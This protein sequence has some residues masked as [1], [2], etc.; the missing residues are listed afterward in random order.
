MMQKSALVLGASGL[1]GSEVLKLCLASDNYNKVITP[2]RSPLIM[3]HKKL[4]EKII[5]FEMPPWKCRL[6]MN[7]FQ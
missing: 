7:C 4:V 3:N 1:V 6:G 2:V 5:D